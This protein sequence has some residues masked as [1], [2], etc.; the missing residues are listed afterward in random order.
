MWIPDTHG[1]G[2]FLCMLHYMYAAFFRAWRFPCIP[3]GASN[4]FIHVLFTDFWL[5]LVPT[6]LA[7]T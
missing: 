5:L 3:H 2:E 6:T 7:P 4:I 1:F